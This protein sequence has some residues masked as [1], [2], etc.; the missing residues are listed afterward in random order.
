MNVGMDVSI[1]SLEA[2]QKQLKLDR[3]P[4]GGRASEAD[5]RFVDLSRQ[6]IGR[7]DAAAVVEVIEHLDPARLSAL[8]R[9]NHRRFERRFQLLD[10]P[11]KELGEPGP[12][13]R[14]SSIAAAS[15]VVE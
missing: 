15:R 11:G 3:L 10:R 7:G 1:R 6:T 12:G 8:E 5:P 2:A 4:A 13:S 9:D 14:P